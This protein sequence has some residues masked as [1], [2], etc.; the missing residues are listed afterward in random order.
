M[1]REELIVR[2]VDAHLEDDNV[3]L[4][5][6]WSPELPALLRSLGYAILTTTGHGGKDLYWP[7]DDGPFVFVEAGP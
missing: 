3:H 1:T 7:T 5:L 4:I 6:P 2:L